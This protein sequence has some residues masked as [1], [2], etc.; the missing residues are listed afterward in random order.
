MVK[1]AK[2][3][4]A[5]ALAL[6]CAAQMTINGYWVFVGVGEPPSPP[7]GRTAVYVDSSTGKL[8]MKDSSGTKLCSGDAPN[9]VASVQ[10]TANEI[11]VAGTTNPVIS[12]ADTFRI[13]GKSATAPTKA[14]SSLPATCQVGDLFYKTDAVAGENLYGCTS[15]NSWSL[16]TPKRAINYTLFDPNAD[17]SAAMDIPSIF[18]NYGSAIVLEEVYCEIDAGS[19][20]IN[21]QRDDGTPAN[22]LTSNLNC[23][24]SGAVTNSFVSGENV[25]Q[26]GHKLDHVTVTTSGTRRINVAI[27]YRWQ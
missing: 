19:T 20:S 14:G 21:L 7:A 2:L 4:L 26:T 10:G 27:K 12:V 13:T 17:L 16:L 3:L 1:S 8:C 24:P 15:T 25:L 5:L 22:I 9:A 23:S 6:P 11:T 18:V